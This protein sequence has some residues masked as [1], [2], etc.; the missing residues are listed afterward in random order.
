MKVLIISP[1]Y[2]PSMGGVETIV[3]QTAEELVR[4]NYTVSVI[5][6]THSNSWVKLSETGVK[7]ENGV[8]VYRLKPQLKLGF[9]SLMGGLGKII[10]NEKPDIIHS[11]DLHPHLFQAIRL[12]NAENFKIVAQ[13]HFPA[14]TG[15]DSRGAKL[16]YPVITRLLKRQQKQVDAFIV[17]TDLE[18][19]WLTDK[20]F[21][22]IRINKLRY[23]CF[24]LKRFENSIEGLD[25]S[26]SQSKL[27][28]PDLLYVGRVTDRKGL[29]VL[30]HAL[31]LVTNTIKNVTLLIAGHA[32]QKY[33]ESLVAL[34]NE[35]NLSNNVVFSDALS[36]EAK[37]ELM[38]KCKVFHSSKH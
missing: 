22:K 31:P 21:D 17:H 36:E 23:P 32:D 29:H 26:V 37:Y 25:Q 16:A 27:V 6:T 10:K 33:Y 24:D 9:A 2:S 38:R 30:L 8:T 18:G 20:G 28:A 12:R 3:K 19:T 4:R 35:L 14:A 15:I 13:L 1:F 5:T 11:H 34:V 7:S